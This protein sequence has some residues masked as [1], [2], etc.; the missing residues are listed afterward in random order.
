MAFGWDVSM[1]TGVPSVDNEHKELFKQV[2]SLT[3]AMREGKGRDEIGKILNFVGDYVVKHFANEEKAMEQYRCPVAEANKAAHKQCIAVFKDL[4][5]R[6]SSAG[7]N[8]SLTIEIHD[9]LKKWLV[10]HI[11]DID[12]KLLSCAKP[13]KKEPE[14]AMSK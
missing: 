9:T 4:Q 8:S 13:A 2:D 6:F 10:N 3:Q 12:T 11:R 14:L 1:T 7:A 5:T